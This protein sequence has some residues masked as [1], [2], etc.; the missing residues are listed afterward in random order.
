M[1]KV[2]LVIS[3]LLIGITAFESEALELP[4]VFGDNMVMQQK[5]ECPIWGKASS[6]ENIEIASSWGEKTTAKAKAN[7]KWEAK[8][9]TPEAGGPYELTIKGKDSTVTFKNVLIGEV[10]VCERNKKRQLS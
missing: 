1:G 9:R 4:S 6:G 5:T 7:G 3:F 2:L 8:L 10:W